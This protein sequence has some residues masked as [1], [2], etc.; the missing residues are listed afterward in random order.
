MF[1]ATEIEFLKALLHT[2]ILNGSYNY[3]VAYTLTSITTDPENYDFYVVMSE[4]PIVGTTEHSFKCH[5]DQI[6]MKVDSSAASR[7]NS[8]PRI[9]YSIESARSFSV[10]DY[11]FVYTNAEGS[12]HADLMAM[13]EYQQANDLSYNLDLNHYYAVPVLLSITLLFTILRWWYPSKG[14][15]I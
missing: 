9:V 14:A 11:E 2:N 5:G 3:Y 8:D 12:I 1:T 10:N 15:R 4:E 6:I 13:Y 7:N